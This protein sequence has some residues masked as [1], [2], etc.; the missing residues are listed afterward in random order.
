MKRFLIALLVCMAGTVAHAQTAVPPVSPSN[1][2]VC[3]NQ[4][5]GG[6]FMTNTS[7][8][9]AELLV[10]FNGVFA[11]GNG[12]A[13]PNSN[14]TI[15]SLSWGPKMTAGNYIGDY[16]LVAV[17]TGFLGYNGNPNC[18]P[19]PNGAIVPY[20]YGAIGYASSLVC[21]GD[22]FA[23]PGSS[24]T[25]YCPDKQIG[26]Y[27]IHNWWSPDW[28]SCLPDFYSIQHVQPNQ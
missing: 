7:Q 14:Y 23:N 15:T 8:C 6:T 24:T 21:P 28:Y 10:W 2:F 9:A 12:G 16:P 13:C 20:S 27:L 1:Q 4:A 26:S 17:G 18:G 25:C 11:H 19:A 22:S 3:V 5:D